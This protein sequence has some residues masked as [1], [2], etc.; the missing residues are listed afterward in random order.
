MILPFRYLISS[1]ICSMCLLMSFSFDALAY[2]SFSFVNQFVLFNR[3]LLLPFHAIGYYFRFKL[4]ETM[5]ESLKIFQNLGAT[6]MVRIF[7]HRIS[8]FRLLSLPL[9]KL[10]N[11][12]LSSVF[13]IVHNLNDQLHTLI[14][15]SLLIVFSVYHRGGSLFCCIALSE[16]QCNLKLGGLWCE[17][18][19]SR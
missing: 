18:D 8:S 9:T 3:R 4:L 7:F 1:S 19:V 6:L 12:T 10:L 14:I 16:T 11:F 15:Q 17:K 5:H 2:S 13:P